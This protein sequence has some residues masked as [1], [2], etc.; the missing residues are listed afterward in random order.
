M[1]SSRAKRYLSESFNSDKVP[2]TY[3]LSKE[4][5]RK[6]T[7]KLKSSLWR[8]RWNQDPGKPRDTARSQPKELSLRWR[9]KTQ[10]SN[11]NWLRRRGKFHSKHHPKETLWGP[12]HGSQKATWTHLEDGLL[13]TNRQTLG[14]WKAFKDKSKQS[15]PHATSVAKRS[16]L[17]REGKLQAP[18]ISL[19]LVDQ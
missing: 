7:N 10:G 13:R 5:S 11:R 6:A 18:G 14:I 19:Y 12:G 4:H 15:M 3:W 9:E 1:N 17:K 2:G 16:L 8:E